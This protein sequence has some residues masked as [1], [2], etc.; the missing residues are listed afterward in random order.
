MKA[1]LGKILYVSLCCLL[2]GFVYIANKSTDRGALAMMEAAEELTGITGTGPTIDKLLDA[3][4]ESGRQKFWS[5]ILRCQHT[6]WERGPGAAQPLCERAYGMATTDEERTRATIERARVMVQ[7][8]IHAEALTMLGQK[9]PIDPKLRVKWHT[10]RAQALRVAGRN[11][12]SVGAA[13]SAHRIVCPTHEPI[14]A[15]SMAVIGIPQKHVD[16]AGCQI[17]VGSAAVAS[18]GGGGASTDLIAMAGAGTGSGMAGGGTGGVY[19]GGGGGG[20]GGTWT[21]TPIGSVAGRVP[22]PVPPIPGAAPAVAPSGI[23]GKAESSMMAHADVD[24]ELGES[25]RLSGNHKQA[26]YYLRSA[27]FAY[28]WVSRQNPEYDLFRLK[29]ARA[30]LSESQLLPDE[31]PELDRDL[32]NVI[33]LHEM[34]KTGAGIMDALRA[35]EPGRW[36][37]TGAL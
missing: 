12:E 35:R 36:E 22:A 33:M 18:G 15:T 1:V 14:M 27:I 17:P 3:V 16:P 6:G 24:Y 19:S 29:V 8:R 30:M 37:Y 11:A 20:G 13:R 10:V 4:D 26:D 21:P 31:I 9:E 5:A 34:H 2:L 7:L 23:Y 25:L 28:D 32:D